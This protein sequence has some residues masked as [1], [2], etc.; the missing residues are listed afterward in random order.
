VE[1]WYYSL[2]KEMDGKHFLEMVP[3]VNKA[4]NG[5]E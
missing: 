2:G 5:K 1:S 3:D 4:K